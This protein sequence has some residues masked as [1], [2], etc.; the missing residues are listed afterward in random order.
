MFGTDSL[1]R[2]LTEL[3]AVATVRHRPSADRI[4]QEVAVLMPE[5]QPEANQSTMPRGLPAALHAQHVVIQSLVI[6]LY[7]VPGPVPFVQHQQATAVTEDG[8]EDTENQD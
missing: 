6:N 3:E 7:A 1:V 2:R 4:E 5:A 8:D